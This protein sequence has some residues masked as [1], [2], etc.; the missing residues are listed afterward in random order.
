MELIIGILALFL[1][2]YIVLMVTK[3]VAFSLISSVPGI[4]ILII[5]ILLFTQLWIIRLRLNP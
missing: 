3:R 1:I 2:I 4:I 5:I